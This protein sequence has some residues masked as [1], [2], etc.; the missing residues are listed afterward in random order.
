MIKKIYLIVSLG[1]FFIESTIMSMDGRDYRFGCRNRQQCQY[2]GL[3]DKYDPYCEQCEF[4]KYPERFVACLFCRKPLRKG[5]VGFGFSECFACFE[6]IE[7]LLLDQLLVKSTSH[8]VSAM[9]QFCDAQQR[10]ALKGGIRAYFKGAKMRKREYIKAFY[11]LQP[12]QD[13]FRSARHAV[14]MPHIYLGAKKGPNGGLLHIWTRELSIAPEDKKPIVDIEEATKHIAKIFRKYK[15]GGPATGKIVEQ[16]V[17]SAM[18]TYEELPNT[19]SQGN[20][21]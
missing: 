11:P 5:P 17:S 6:S 1:C 2:R 18:I 16:E 20:K 3:V 7:R 21:K 10:Q 14:A 12:H 19:E 8:D 9:S 13:I 4:D 15:I